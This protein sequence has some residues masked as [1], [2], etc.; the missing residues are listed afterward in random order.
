MTSRT[1]TAESSSQVQCSATE[2][3]DYLFVMPAYRSSYRVRAQGSS[4]VSSGSVGPERE[5]SFATEVRRRSRAIPISGRGLKGHTGSRPG[6]SS[7]G[8]GEFDDVSR[9]FVA[10]A[11]LRRTGENSR[12]I[13][14]EFALVSA[15]CHPRRGMR[16]EWL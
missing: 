9:G 8:T 13:A 5:A 11:S 14:V 3:V 2:A 12:P 15:R 1:T 4:P 7:V 16:R 6:D 10:A